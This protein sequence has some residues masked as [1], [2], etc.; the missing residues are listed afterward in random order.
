LRDLPDLWKITG[1]VDFIWCYSIADFVQYQQALR[2]LPDL[3]KITGLVD[4]IWCYSI[5]DFVER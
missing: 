5:A 3:W 2:D 1:L 4:F